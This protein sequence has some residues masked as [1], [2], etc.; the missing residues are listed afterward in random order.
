MLAHSFQMLFQE[1]VETAKV[2]LNIDVI[3]TC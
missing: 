3:D 1:I 2:L